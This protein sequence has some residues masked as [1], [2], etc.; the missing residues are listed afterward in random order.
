MEYAKE[1]EVNIISERTGIDLT[2]RHTNIDKKTQQDNHARWMREKD[3]ELRL[4][5]KT[6]VYLKLGED[7]LSH[8]K[9]VYDKVCEK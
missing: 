2:L 4:L 1:R 7:S 6:E 9:S 5:K 8:T 3:R